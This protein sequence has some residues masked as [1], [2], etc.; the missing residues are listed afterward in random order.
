MRREF[1][2]NWFSNR[3]YLS[4]TVKLK[5][6]FSAGLSRSLSQHNTI[7]RPA[8]YAAI[9]FVW[10]DPFGWFK[11]WIMNNEK[12][13][14]YILSFF[15]RTKHVIHWLTRYWLQPI[16]GSRGVCLIFSGNFG[17]NFK[18]FIP[19]IYLYTI[20][21]QFTSTPIFE[22]NNRKEAKLP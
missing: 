7:T 12:T 9:G 18:R 8:P 22:L 16:F 14:L 5:P 15:A 19:I 4:P 2:W 20:I 6:E 11:S 17:S 21:Y 3:R 10:W 13:Y 1:S